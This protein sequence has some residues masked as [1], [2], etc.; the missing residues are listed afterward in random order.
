[1]MKP[2]KQVSTLKGRETKGTARASA[3]ARL[4]TFPV[5]GWG[6]AGIKAQVILA[7]AESLV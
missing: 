6:K 7:W 1:M 2:P 5:G 4:K 3:W